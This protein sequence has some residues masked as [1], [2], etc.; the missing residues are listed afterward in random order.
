MIIE[1]HKAFSPNELS[2]FSQKFPDRY[3]SL[4]KIVGELSLKNNGICL[5]INLPH[6]KDFG[7]VSV[8]M[9]KSCSL[10]IIDSRYF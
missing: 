2:D 7:V 5:E 9:P 4:C 8:G 3:K 1:I 6:N 10:E